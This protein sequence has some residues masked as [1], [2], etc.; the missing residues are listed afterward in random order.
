MLNQL[1]TFEY[2]SSHQKGGWL[3]FA[4][5]AS[6]II[7][8][9][10]LLAGIGAGVARVV[11][12]GDVVGGATGVLDLTSG[13]RALRAL[14]EGGES[15][16]L[17][18]DAA[19][20]CS[21]NSFTADTPVLLAN[22]REE[23]I[24]KIEVGDKVLATD[25]KTG[26]T[27]ARPVTK[28][29]VHSGE[30]TMVDVTL[31]DGT[32]LTATDHHPFWDA[33]TDQFAYAV[34]L[35]VG[36]RVREDN[37]QL[38]AIARV[39]PFDE[40]VTAYNLTVDGIHTYYAGTTPVLVHNSCAPDLDALSGSGE[41]PIGKQG[42]TKAGASLAQ[43][44]LDLGFSE[45]DLAGGPANLNA[46]GQDPLNDIL[47]DPGSTF[48]SP[49]TENFAGGMRVISPTGAGATFDANGVFRYFGLYAVNP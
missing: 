7:P 10:D 47:T 41:S 43:H 38:I 17:L 21:V 4:L 14:G 28:I 8:V 19:E 39:Y 20:S 42:M 31:T 3:D 23:P 29:I 5:A 24:G 30:H 34:D 40:N 12:A 1:T 26:T 18:S 13:L 9:D 27:E 44:G 36:D 49:T 37:G 25:P 46:L 6:S 32:M 2:Q 22:G 45:A 35:H 33:T 48:S 16:G 15:G 11:R